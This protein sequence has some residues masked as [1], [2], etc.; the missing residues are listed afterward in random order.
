MKVF[1][2]SFL[3]VGLTFYFGCYID[4]IKVYC[5]DMVTEHPEDITEGAR[6][7][8]ITDFLSCLHTNTGT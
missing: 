8:I 3:D 7:N 6:M 2:T 1:I 4:V 5:Q